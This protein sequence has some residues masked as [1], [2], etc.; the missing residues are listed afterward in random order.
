MADLREENGEQR[1]MGIKKRSK[2]RGD[3]KTD[4]FTPALIINITSLLRR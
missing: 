4:E 3:T 2:K 1:N